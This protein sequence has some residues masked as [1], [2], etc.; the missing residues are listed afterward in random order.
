M[1]NLEICETLDL[2]NFYLQ[3]EDE[4][5]TFTI[6]GGA[7]IVLRGIRGRGTGDIDIIAPKIDRTLKEA[8][9]KVANDLELGED[10]LNDKPRKFYAKDLPIGWENRKIEVYTASHLTVHSVS[11][12][13]LAVLKFLAECDRHKDFQDIVDLNLSELE[14]VQVVKH[15][16]IRDPGDVKNWPGIVAKVEERLRKKM[17]YETR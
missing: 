6:C 17:G 12:F 16:L 8:S 15:A 9:L 2:L 3:K 7:S 1:S 4:L 13:D 14:L 5:R 10:W 11:N